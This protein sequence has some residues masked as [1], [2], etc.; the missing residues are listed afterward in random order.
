[1]KSSRTIN[2]AWNKRINGSKE[3]GVSRK[4]GCRRKRKKLILTW[5]GK[6]QMKNRDKQRQNRKR[7]EEML[8]IRNE[9]GNY[10]P[11]PYEAVKN[12]IQEDYKNKGRRK[13]KC[14]A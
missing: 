14:D 6:R 3:P 5:K 11:T 13:Q 8:N 2:L 7:K 9:Y 12:I 1:M 4:R 10:D